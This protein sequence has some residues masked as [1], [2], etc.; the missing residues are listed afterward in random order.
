MHRNGLKMDKISNLPPFFFTFPGFFWQ[1]FSGFKISV[2]LDGF[3]PLFF[4]QLFFT[5]K[6]PEEKT[7]THN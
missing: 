1:I 6:P 2:S 5:E 3:F 7:T 4:F